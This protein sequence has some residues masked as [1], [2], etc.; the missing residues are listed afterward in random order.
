MNLS[1]LAFSA[2]FILFYWLKHNKSR[3]KITDMVIFLISLSLAIFISHIMFYSKYMD[4]F[5]NLFNNYFSSFIIFLILISI[6][7]ARDL[8]ND[9]IKLGEY[10][11]LVFIITIGSVLLINTNNML[12]MFIS[13]ELISMSLYGIIAL[14]KRIESIE[15]S[16]KYFIL[17][18]FASIFMIISLFL[19]YLFSQTLNLN[20]ISLQFLN[21]PNSAIILSIILFLAGFIFKLALFPFS[22]WSVDIYTAS[23]TNVVLFIVGAVKLSI[24]IATFR[25][26][27]SINNEILTLSTYTFILFTLIIPNISALFTRNIKKIIAYSSISHAGY[28]SISFL[29]SDG[30]QTYFYAIVYTIS[31]VGV[32]SIIYLLE[33][34][35]SDIDYS[36]IKSLYYKKPLVAL[37]L[38][39][40]MFSLAGVPP[41][42]GF[43]AKFYVFYNAL[44]AGYKWLVILA[45]LTSAISLYYYIK[46]LIPVF[47][48]S[49]DDGKEIK[50]SKN[51]LLII[52]FCALTVLLLGLFSQKL[53]NILKLII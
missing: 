24:I 53:I 23:P 19:M 52:Y 3:I 18:T 25:V 4:F 10:Y 46:I 31:T 7:S 47:F 50:I 38:A 49:S 44:N 40:F 28:I 34:N 22:S 12:N 33:K 48:D 37:S 20:E 21:T 5:S 16:I 39:I 17:G 41:L 45:A 29:G 15:A 51:N 35:Y 6:V 11:F 13:L 27:H 42:S 36:N 2:I 30:W 9:R 43:F 26:F 8:L 32:F 1:F 14:D